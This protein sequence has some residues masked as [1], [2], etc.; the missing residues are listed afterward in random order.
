M[1]PSRH[2]QARALPL[3]VGSYAAAAVLSLFISAQFLRRSPT[4][5]DLGLWIGLGVVAGLL[6][7]RAKGLSYGHFWQIF[8]L[9][10]GVLALV[11]LFARFVPIH[12][13]G[14]AK[15]IARYIV[16]DTTMARWL[17]GTAALSWLHE[18]IFKIPAVSQIAPAAK[19]TAVYLIR[20]VGILVMVVG[21]VTLHRRWPDRLSI[22]LPTLLPIWLLFSVG[23]LEYYPLIAVALV[24][25]LAWIFDRPLADRD[26]YRVGALA[27]ALFPLLYVAY[28]PVSLLILLFYGIARPSK[29]LRA[30][31]TAA[32][33][34]VIGIVIFW[35]QGVGAFINALYSSLNLGEHNILF[36]PYSGHA[37]GPDSVLFTWSYTLSTQHL[38]HL[39]FMWHFGAGTM[40]ALLFLAGSVL[41][42]LRHGRQTVELA[43]YKRSW[44]GLALIG[45]HLFYM[46]R[47]IPKLGPAR[48]V[49]LFF[50]VYIVVAFFAGLL[51]DRGLDPDDS[52]RELA[53]L[54]VLAIALGSLAALG[55]QL[56]IHGIRPG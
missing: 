53:T 56:A 3:V 34:A 50:N 20:L 23:Y 29:A 33:V 45:W 38:K 6:V 54:V 21:T 47:M 19:V 1:G 32:V 36:K 12:R 17:A 30:V 5:G 7:T 49:D 44:L 35:P 14:D 16:Q 31:A 13:Y 10:L 15:Y 27:A 41:L 2:L 9:C 46:L 55:S 22:A 11:N 26:P 4:W 52:R 42:L 25:A 18:A 8:W 40:M 24:A 43:R 39:G 51:L 28:A 37:A 48:D